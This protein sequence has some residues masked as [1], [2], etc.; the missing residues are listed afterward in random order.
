M[1]FPAGWYPD[2]QDPR[3]V[4]YWDGSGW[5]PHTAAAPQSQ[6]PQPQQQ[7]VPE[8]PA[9]QSSST[10][11]V[12][13]QGEGQQSGYGQGGHGQYGHAGSGYGAS[14]HTGTGH[15]GYGQPTYGQPGYG[16]PGSDQQASGQQAAG[17]SGYGQYGRLDP[18]TAGV[19]G[20]QRGGRGRLVAGVVI[21]VVIAVVLLLGGAA[22]LGARLGWW[23]SEPTAGPATSSDDG[24]GATPDE[25]PTDPGPTDVESTDPATDVPPDTSAEG[26]VEAV[27]TSILLLDVGACFLTLTPEGEDDGTVPHIDCSQ[28]HVDEIY[29]RIELEGE[30]TYP[31]ED[32]V[33]RAGEDRCE[34]EFESFVG[35]SYATSVL[36]YYI[37]YPTQVTW[38][39]HDDRKVTCV[40][41]EPGVETVVGSLRGAAR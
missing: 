38:E 35:M 14:G 33:I 10:P 26:P 4:R 39:G 34:A 36:D 27:E 6:Q 41:Y 9:Q 40:V 13:G 19:P 31:G 7:A 15:T 37:Y 24:T 3:L 25:D 30:D 18:A 21:A 17:Q 2:P 20:A 8:R 5:T 22:A 11:P 32:K 23:S 29:A 1:S 28:P 12:P 16:Q